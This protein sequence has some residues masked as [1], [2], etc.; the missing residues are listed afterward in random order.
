MSIVCLGNNG[1]LFNWGR[2]VAKLRH[3]PDSET[4]GVDM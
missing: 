4:T 2:H 3:D 1:Y